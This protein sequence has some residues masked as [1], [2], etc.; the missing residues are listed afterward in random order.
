MHFAGL[1]PRQRP[2]NRR[3]KVCAVLMVLGLVAVVL[4]GCAARPTVGGV[5]GVILT[6]GGTS[7]CQ[8]CVRP[9]DAQMVFQTTKWQEVLAIRTR[10]SG[11]FRGQLAPGT[12]YLREFDS[13]GQCRPVITMR[14]VADRTTRLRLICTDVPPSRPSGVRRSRPGRSWAAG[15]AGLARDD[16]A[17]R[18]SR[19]PEHLT[20]WLDCCAKFCSSAIGGRCGR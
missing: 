8:T 11:S 7:S 9:D 20:L 5:A 18:A 19:A 1:L 10:A 15:T 14:V 3:T 4:C 13:Y 2:K 17:A 16:L 6:R 12:Y